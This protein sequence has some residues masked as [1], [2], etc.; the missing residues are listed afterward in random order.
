MRALLN[1]KKWANS[2]KPKRC[3][4]GG[5]KHHIGQLVCKWCK[6]FSQCPIIKM[7]NDC[8]CLLYRHRA[9]YFHI[10]C[11]KF[12]TT[13]TLINFI[14]HIFVPYSYLTLSHQWWLTRLLI[15]DHSLTSFH[16][17]TIKQEAIVW[18]Q[19]LHQQR[20]RSKM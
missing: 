2:S 15:N 1:W 9:A 18:I 6:V 12:T 10:Q 19:N 8:T 3:L 5:C 13:C 17:L 14:L 4:Q 11:W 16:L 7:Y 20:K